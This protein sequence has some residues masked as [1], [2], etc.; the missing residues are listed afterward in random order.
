MAEQELPGLVEDFAAT[1]A[2][3]AF[4]FGG[5]AGLAGRPIPERVVVAETA[6]SDIQGLAGGKT[7]GPGSPTVP[8]RL[9]VRAAVLDEGVH[10]T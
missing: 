7:I 1:L 3:R 5:L 2:A 10:R 8:A 9:S 6:T 4:E